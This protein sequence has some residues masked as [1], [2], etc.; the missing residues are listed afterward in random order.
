MGIPL[1]N[2]LV[3]ERRSMAIYHILSDSIGHISYYV[4]SLS[5]TRS[6]NIISRIDFKRPSSGWANQQND[7]NANMSIVS[8][9]LTRHILLSTFPT[10]RGDV[11]R[12]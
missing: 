11:V 1:A 6:Y 2:R 4:N 12:Q 7:E 5:D 8:F 10:V 3:H 9:Y